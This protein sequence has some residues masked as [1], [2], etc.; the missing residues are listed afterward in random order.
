MEC[1]GEPCWRAMGML[2]MRALTWVAHPHRC[3]WDGD[4]SRHVRQRALQVLGMEVGRDRDGWRKRSSFYLGGWTSCNTQ[5]QNSTHWVLAN[6]DTKMIDTKIQLCQFFD[7]IWTNHLNHGYGSWLDL[8]KV[9]WNQQPG[10]QQVRTIHRYEVVPSD[11]CRKRGD[12]NS[13]V[14]DYY[15][16]TVIGIKPA[17]HKKWALKI[18]P[19]IQG[20]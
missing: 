9:H 18:S 7:R 5:M 10:Y 3:S 13:L 15:S 8:K 12:V 1:Y 11:E 17:T 20:K 14:N 19:C 4:V 16:A 6:F 2:V